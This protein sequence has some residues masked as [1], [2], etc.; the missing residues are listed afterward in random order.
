MQS[1]GESFRLGVDIAFPRREQLLHAVHDTVL[2]VIVIFPEIRRAQ[3][4]EPSTF[5]VELLSALVAKNFSNP[6]PS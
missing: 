6:K 1:R 4:I 2:R 5:T 3:L